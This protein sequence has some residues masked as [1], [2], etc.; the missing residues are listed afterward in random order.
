[1]AK[2]RESQKVE[3]AKVAYDGP[4]NKGWNLVTK[5]RLSSKNQITIPVAICRA[6][7]MRPGD[8][9]LLIPGT[10]HLWIERA[11]RTPEEWIAKTQGSMAHVEEWSTKQ[12]VD[13]WVRNERDSWDRE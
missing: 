11:P 6:L 8:E 1:M 2:K 7:D 13:A 10:D 9:I 5:T 3:E 4:G 12:K